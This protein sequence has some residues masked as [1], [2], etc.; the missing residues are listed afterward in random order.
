MV[1]Y[2]A[3]TLPEN[4]D[5]TPSRRTVVWVN[6]NRGM[7]SVGDLLALLAKMAQKRLFPRNSDRD[8]TPL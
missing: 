5:L 4:M 7:P 8:L 2:P 3:W 1:G 6:A